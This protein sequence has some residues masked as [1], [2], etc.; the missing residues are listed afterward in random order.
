MLFDDL[1]IDRAA[2]A[3]LDKQ[4]LA[5]LGERYHSNNL[6]YLVKFVGRK[7]K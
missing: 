5:A 3:G 6:K 1:R 4:E 2:F 7:A